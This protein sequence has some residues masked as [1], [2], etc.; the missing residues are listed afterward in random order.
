MRTNSLSLFVH[1]TAVGP[2]TGFSP[3]NGC[4][5]ELVVLEIPKLAPLSNVLH[6]IFALLSHP[7]TSLAHTPEL[8]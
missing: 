4:E 6:L 2:V 7:G 5:P 8:P 1:A 3:C